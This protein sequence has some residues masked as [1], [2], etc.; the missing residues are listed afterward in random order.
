M[1]KFMVIGLGNFGFQVAKS[2]FDQ[3]NEVLAVD[4]QKDVVQQ[5]GEYS[6]RAVI[7]DAEDKEF[8]KN[9]GATEMDA[10]VVSLG[11]NISQS[12]I[13]VL[14]LK[15]LGAGYIIAKA[16]DINHGKALRKVGADRVVFP[17]REMAVKLAHKL[18]SPSVI[19]SVDLSEDYVITELLAPLGL[20]GKNL[21][22][23]DL[24][25]AY[26]VLVIAV[27]EAVPERVLVL[28]PPDYHIK[29]SDVLVLLGKTEDISKLEKQT[30][31][32]KA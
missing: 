27:K 29:D 4:R 5:I 18:T 21:I 11:D 6:S 24:R 32:A 15:E 22:E 13:I 14:F 3:G 9:I 30:R 17:E 10:V 1:K 20:V 16:N 2:L 26:N 7:A 28:P 12:I 8:L 23:L 31:E 19:D 25:K